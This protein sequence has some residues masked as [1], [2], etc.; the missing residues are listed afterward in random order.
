MLIKLSVLPHMAQRKE[1]YIFSIDQP[2]T[3]PPS[4][5]WIVTQHPLVGSDQNVK[6]TIRQTKQSVRL[7]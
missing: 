7:L 5:E 3:H 4:Q 1:C 6:L 2:P